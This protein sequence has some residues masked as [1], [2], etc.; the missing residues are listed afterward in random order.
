MKNTIQ[1]LGAAF[2]GGLLAIGAFQTW[3]P[4]AE[5]SI[6][7]VPQE[8]VSNSTSTLVGQSKENTYVDLTLAAQEVVTEVVHVKTKKAGQEYVQ[9]DPYS[10]FHGSPQGRKFKSP[11]QKGSGSGVVIRE[12]GYIVTNNHVIEGADEVEV[13]FNNNQSYRATVVGA[14][15]STDLALLKVDA[16]ALTPIRLGNSDDLK[17]GQW[18]LAVGNPYNLNS[19]VTAGIVSAKARNINIL[20]RNTNTP[21]LEAFI[22]T[23]A[24]VNPGNSGGALVNASGELVGINSAIQSPTGSY[25]GYSFAIPV[26]IMKKVVNDI[27][28]YGVVQRAFIGVS[29]QNVSSELAEKESLHTLTGVY[30][31]E[32]I[33]GGAA[34]KA[35]LESGDVITAIN[36][37]E[38]KNV[39]ELQAQIGVHLPGDEVGV[40]VERAG[41][42]KLFKLA[43]RN[44]K[45]TTALVEATP[46]AL[47]S[48]GADLVAVDTGVLTQLGISH[49]VQVQ[50]LGPGKLAKSGIREGFIITRIDGKE[51][52]DATE[53]NTVLSQKS[54][55]VLVEGLYPNGAKKYY[56]LAM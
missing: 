37:T 26:N 55:G 14:D 21:P 44:N 36:G 17:L 53:V 35:G 4:L 24:A 6:V 29:I 47:A 12:D 38:V 45:G 31:N 20:S 18:V 7:Y 43:L 54:G 51:V 3:S 16:D 5:Q 52:T 2:V 10:F 41:T 9:L 40:L 50:Q 27:M 46:R 28:E 25:S 22:Q 8:V 32:V 30:V 1:L 23:D 39:A 15:P 56:G 49:G 33:S 48:L 34:A 11:D 42:T 19:T 13:V